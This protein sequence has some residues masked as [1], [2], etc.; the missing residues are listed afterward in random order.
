[1]AYF[2]VQAASAV[3]ADALG[4]V[5]EKLDAPDG[6]RHVDRARYVDEIG[7]D[8]RVAI[9]YWDDPAAF[10]RWFAAFRPWWDSPDIAADGLGH[11]IELVRPNLERFETLFSSLGKPEGIGVLATGMSEPINEHVTSACRN[12]SARRRSHE[13]QGEEALRARDDALLSRARR[14]AEE[15]LCFRA[16]RVSLLPELSDDLA[17]F[18]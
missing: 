12:E 1:M 11:F 13:P 15:A 10:D 14:P 18:A 7:Y 9:A 5:L 3:P 2:G 6:A 4:P 8:T 17:K 16:R